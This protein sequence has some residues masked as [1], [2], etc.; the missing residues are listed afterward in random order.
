L[1]Y[2]DNGILSAGSH[3]V[4]IGLANG[5]ILYPALWN[6]T[7]PIGVTYKV[8]Y[9][10]LN[11]LNASPCWVWMNSNSTVRETGQKRAD[12]LSAVY[13]QII[14]N[15]TFKTFD[16]AY[17]DFPFLGI[18]SEWQKRGGQLYQLLEPIDGFHPSSIANY[19]MAEYM[20][21]AILK[22]HPTFIGLQN[23]NNDQ[24]KKLFGD[25]GGY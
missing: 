9:D 20:F 17:Y 3:V 25:Q 23:P 15:Y 13:N 2:L 1:N 24:I 7:H 12:E 10:Y 21:A 18:W 4:F 22:D 8:V 19:L 16:M 5:D 6:R 11:C 14:G